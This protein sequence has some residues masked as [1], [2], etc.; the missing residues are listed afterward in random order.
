MII[1]HTS[2][3]VAIMKSMCF[4][5]YQVISTIKL[6]ILRKRFTHWYS[7]RLRFA[8]ELQ[9]VTQHLEEHT[10]STR[11]KTPNIT[12]IAW[13][14]VWLLIEITGVRW[15]QYE[16]VREWMV[17]RRKCGHCRLLP[18]VSHTLVN[19]FLHGSSKEQRADDNSM[20]CWIQTPSKWGGET[21]THW[22]L[23]LAFW[24]PPLPSP[25]LDPPLVTWVWKK[26]S[27]TQHWRVHYS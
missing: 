7:S 18:C 27:Q 16:N 13:Q 9:H 17:G 26:N 1:T 6:N 5:F 15:F 4:L 12:A 11:I 20:Q 24:T 14:N 10:E 3:F 2:Q 19:K 25:L 8:E 22:N 23:F 21:V